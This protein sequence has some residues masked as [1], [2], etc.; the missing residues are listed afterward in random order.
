MKSEKFEWIADQASFERYCEKW[1]TNDWLAID[2]EFIREKTFYPVPAL[3]QVCDGVETCLIDVQALLNWDSF[4]DLMNSEIIWVMHSCSEDI[5]LLHFLL[6]TTPSNLFDTQVAAN[7]LGM[8]QSLSYQNL[9]HLLM[10]KQL[11]KSATRT[12]WLQRP[13]D[14]EQLSYAAND[15]IYLAKFWE[16]LNEML[17]KKN[18]KSYFEQ[19]MKTSSDFKDSDP[20]LMYQKVKG[21]NALPEEDLFTLKALS[22][23]R[24]K[25]A[26]RRNKPRKFIIR[27]DRLILLSSSRPQSISELQ[28]LEI[29]TPKQLQM[30]GKEILEQL[31]KSYV[32]HFETTLPLKMRFAIQSRTV[33][34]KWKKIA[35]D[36]ALE[37]NIS[38]S[39]LISNRLLNGVFRWM[40]ETDYQK[41]QLWNQWRQQL[42]QSVFVDLVNDEIPELDIT[43]KDLLSVG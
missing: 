27:D 42:L 35:S 32:P 12:N 30:Y 19:D 3:L 15:V 28:A 29:I 1:V 26:R 5:E 31:M 22:S 20:E 14:A 34:K 24:E 37:N 21:A 33:I 7:F 4:S 36:I 41:P 39:A 6:G 8:G 11:D 38:V 9:V 2:T 25:T 18:L 13:L 16:I 43:C 40:T 23:W 17:I 10:E